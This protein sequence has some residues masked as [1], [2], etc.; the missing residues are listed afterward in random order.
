MQPVAGVLTE[1]KDSHCDLRFCVR[2]CSGNER[3][4]RLAGSAI[5]DDGQ[6]MDSADIGRGLREAWKSGG[7]R[8]R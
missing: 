4:D 2:S 3:A 5:T 6:P 7:L 8:E 1:V